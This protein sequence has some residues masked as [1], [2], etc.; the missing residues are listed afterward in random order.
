M[1]FCYLLFCFQIN[2]FPK[3]HLGIQRKCQFGESRS[4]FGYKLFA[5]VIGP[6]KTPVFRVTQPYLNLLVKPRNFFRFSGKNIIVCIL[7]GNM[8]F[9]M[10]KMIYFSRKKIYMPTL[11]KIFRHI[12][13]N[14]LIFLFGFSRPQILLAGKGI[15]GFTKSFQY[16]VLIHGHQSNSFIA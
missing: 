2:I 12:T 5:N 3:I 1:I 6:K 14:T 8:P 13:R 11:P 4:L 9:K 16:T 15:L 10:H 7:K